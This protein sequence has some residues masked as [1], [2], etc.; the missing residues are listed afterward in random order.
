MSGPKKGQQSLI[1]YDFVNRPGKFSSNH[2][3]A[4]QV[5]RALKKNLANPRRNRAIQEVRDRIFFRTLSRDGDAS[6]PAGHVIA[7]SGVNGKEG[8]TTLTFLLMLALGELKHNRILYVDGRFDSQSF[9]ANK[10]VFDLRKLPAHASNG[11]SYLECYGT[12][13]E[14]YCFLTSQKNV[15]PV[16]FFSDTEVSVFLGE[17]RESFNYILFDMPP[18]LPSSETR[19]ILPHTDL[20]FLTVCPG[21][22]LLADVERCKGIVEEIGKPID[23]IILNRQRLPLWTRFFGRES[24]L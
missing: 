3:R 18:F 1:R 12:K 5:F 14:S 23:G 22:T 10:E 17:L 4:L 24:F 8:V 16:K 21:K 13:N 19:Q 11:Y 15:K 7:L 9:L 6:A 2:K 20:F